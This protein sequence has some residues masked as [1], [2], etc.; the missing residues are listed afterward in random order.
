MTSPPRSRSRAATALFLATL[1]AACTAEAP[2][3]PADAPPPDA[4]NVP[5]DDAT[6]QGA[7]DDDH[8][9]EAATSTADAQTTYERV[10]A[11]LPARGAAGA[12]AARE[13]GRAAFLVFAASW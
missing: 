5:A 1:L 4:E 3:A 9:G 6:E 8:A 2:E 10:V 13:E 12:D 7:A 11:S